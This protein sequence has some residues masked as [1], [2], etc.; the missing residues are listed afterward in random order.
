MPWSAAV[1]L[2]FTKTCSN[3]SVIRAKWSAAMPI[4]ESSTSMIQR[5]GW[6]EGLVLSVM[7]PRWVNLTA[8][9]RRLLTI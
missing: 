8:L 1:F 9:S 4:P 7:V 5:S 6:A 2:G 3:G